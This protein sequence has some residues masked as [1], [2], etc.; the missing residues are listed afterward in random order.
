MRLIRIVIG[1]ALIAAAAVFGFDSTS[2]LL[3][4]A[5]V[6]TP[7]QRQAALAVQT[8]PASMMT[9][10][11]TVEAVG[12][13][14][15]VRAVELTQPPP[16]ASALHIIPGAEVRAGAVLLRL[17]DAA[18]RAALKSAEAT[19]AE[20]R[21]AYDRQ[22]LDSSGST[23]GAAIEAAQA[24]LLR[25]EAERDMAQAALDDPELRALSRA[26]SV[27]RPCARPADPGPISSPRLTICRASRLAFAC[28]EGRRADR[29]RAWGQ[30]G[31]RCVARAGLRRHDQRR[32]HARRSGD[33]L[34]RVAGGG[35]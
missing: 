33:A 14:R 27:Q 32:R 18:E 35:R 19:L 4:A 31:L 29:A 28:P 30:S 34:D 13:T 2:A 1:A 10:A 26:W 6:R 3:S 7:H 25:A 12:T 21:A 11:D 22:R 23:T 9:F 16:A 24:T 17:E 20:A 15:A 8:V 5:P